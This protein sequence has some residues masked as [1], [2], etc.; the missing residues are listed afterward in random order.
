MFV[1]ARSVKA[2][3]EIQ[4]F[5]TYAGLR[6]K[7]FYQVSR[8]VRPGVRETE[9]ADCFQTVSHCNEFLC[10]S[11]WSYVFH[12]P[13]GSQAH[14]P[15]GRNHRKPIMV[16]YDAGVNAEFDFYTTDTSRAWVMKDAAPGA[17][18]A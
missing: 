14:A 7:A 5:R 12:R 1:L 16:K 11:S 18:P 13:F 2:E 6:M 4:M 8:M 10:T 15:G 3:D 9:M 17:V